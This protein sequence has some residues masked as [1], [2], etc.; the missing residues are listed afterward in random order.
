MFGRCLRSV[1]EVCRR[2]LRGYG[3]CLGCVLEVVGR[4]LGGFGKFCE[5]FERCL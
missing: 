3:R 2:C 1:W 4:H 5:V